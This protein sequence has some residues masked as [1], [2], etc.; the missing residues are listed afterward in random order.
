MLRRFRR[1]S[2]LFSAFFKRYRQGIIATTI[3]TVAVFFA[4]PQL[5]QRLPSGLPREKIGRVG[6]FR[7]TELPTD[8]SNL[9]SMG[10][11]NI[12]PDGT[13]TPA[14]ALS[15]QVEDNGQ[16]YIFSLNPTLTWHD[17][18]PFQ[19]ADINFSFG[20]IE[21]NIIT[22][23][24]VEFKLKEPFAPFPQVVSTPL[25]RQIR[26]WRR[27]FNRS[28][29]P[30]IGLDDYRV[31]D[32]EYKGQFVSTLRLRS[33]KE[34]RDYKFY[35]TEAA[36]ILGFKLGEVDG[37][38]E[39]A[40]PDEL[41]SWPNL[42]IA[43]NVHRDRYVAIFFNTQDALL[44]DKRLRQALSYAIPNKDTYGERALGPLN[45]NSWAYN[46]QV[47][48]YDTDLEH[49]QE[50]I[51]E[52][53]DENENFD[54]TVRLDTTLAYL[55]LAETIKTSWESI[56]IPTE[57]RVVNFPSD[58]Y[59][60]LLAVHHIPPDPDQYTLWHSTQ[61][62]N[63]THLKSPKIDKL[64]EDGRKTTD[65]GERRTIYQDFQRFLLEEAPAAFLFYQTTYTV[66][67]K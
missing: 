63:F 9:V 11:T 2:W 26:G 34:I 14:A 64:L 5:L 4:I 38:E 8:I 48:P 56:G 15:W 60:A 52:I 16:R 24:M 17:G 67:R 3:I 66:T 23:V 47:K 22:S 19:A 30:L 42:T 46:P 31:T 12:N 29:G 51:D 27:L 44:S 37:L 45:P 55:A 20:D 25:F 53:K 10:L 65:K 1:T 50:L 41:K 61:A 36:A 13:A 39:L 7:L 18:M 35:T 49:A 33:P 28:Q 43:P 59:Q 57:V 58:Q 32:A 6:Q 40:N 54:P 21:T 62:T